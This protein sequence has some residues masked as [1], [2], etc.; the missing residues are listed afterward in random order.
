MKNVMRFFKDWRKLSFGCELK[1]I[2]DIK[3]SIDINCMHNRTLNNLVECNLL[4]DIRNSSKRTTNI[5]GYYSRIL[6]G[7]MNT[8]RVRVNI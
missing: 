2:Y 8:H 3:C 5:N 6:Y 7:C 1:N 4:N